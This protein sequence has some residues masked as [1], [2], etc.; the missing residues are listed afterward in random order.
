MQ[1]TPSK[2]QLT[3]S[4]TQLTPLKMQLTY[5]L[6]ISYASALYNSGMS[7]DKVN[8][9]QGKAKNKT[10]AAYFMTNPDDLKYEY[11]KHQAARLLGRLFLFGQIKTVVWGVSAFLSAGIVCRILRLEPHQQ[12]ILSAEYIH[13]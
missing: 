5:F 6:L 2:M 10:D 12:N 7:L 4:K 1:L 8:D 9:L 3:P 13:R 11:I